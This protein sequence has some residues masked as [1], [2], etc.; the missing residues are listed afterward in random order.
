MMSKRLVEHGKINASSF[1]EV[2]SELADFIMQE[3]YGDEYENYIFRDE[4]GAYNYTEEGQD[5]FNTYVGD[6]EK[7]LNSAGI[8][9]E[10]TED[11][12]NK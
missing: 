1:L 5:I 10:D 3:K 2:T 7:Y 4:D 8:Y 9:H 6:V 11:N 12:D